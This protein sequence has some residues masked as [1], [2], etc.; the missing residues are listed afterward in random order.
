MAGQV[1]GG[2]TDRTGVGEERLCQGGPS[3]VA[4]VPSQH[5]SLVRSLHEEAPRVS[6]DGVRG[7]RQSLQ[8]PALSP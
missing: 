2:E 7:R 8:C 5:N 3:F 6:G 4:G 1:R